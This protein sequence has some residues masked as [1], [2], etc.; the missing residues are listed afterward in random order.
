MRKSEIDSKKHEIEEE[1]FLEREA[2]RRMREGYDCDD[3]EG[4]MYE[5]LDD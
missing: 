4:E 5:G 3:E 2:Q 1:R